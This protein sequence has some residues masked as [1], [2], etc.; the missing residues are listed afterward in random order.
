M[1][2]IKNYLYNVVYQVLL[3]IV[4]LIT[5]PY[6][7]RVLGP[8]LVGINSYTNSWMTFFMLIGQMGISLYGNREIA[9]HRENKEQ[10]S[11]IFWGIEA[12]QLLTILFALALYITAVMLFSTTFKRYFLL[13]TF[14]IIAA[15]VDVSWY[16]MGMENF[17]RTVTR[18]LVVKIISVIMILALIKNHNDLGK[19]IVILGGS[20]LV[21]NLT[22]WPYLKKEIV[23]VPLIEWKPFSHFYPSLLLFIPTITTQ[24]YLVVNRLMLGRMS[25]QNQLGQFE[26]TDKIIKIILAVVTASGQVM[27]P[28][29]ANKFSNGNVKGVRDSLYNSFDF[30]T[31]LAV[32]MMFGVMAVAEPLAPWFLGQAF[33]PA[34]E[35]MMV[36][37]PIIL[38]IAWS[39]VTGIQYLMPVNRTNEYTISVSIGA[40]VNIVANMFLIAL[41]AAKG[42][43]LATDVS[44]FAVTAVQLYYIRNTISRRKLFSS[45]WKYLLCGLV[46]FLI[47]FRLSHMIKMSV[48]NLVVEV[49]TGALAYVV[50]I[51]LIH[52]P[53]VDQA[54]H[55]ISNRKKDQNRGNK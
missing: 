30:I 14:W 47:V 32:P 21:G 40:V 4:P 54:L 52:A 17:Q 53:I 3:L 55:L 37:A 49:I 1:K 5:V 27:L 6:I 51:I 15:G 33:A 11:K 2:V 9:Y 25:T 45:V 29:I 20:N 34:G 28:H 26:N 18:N 16:F 31:A 35:L 22:L 50:G 42:A 43:A 39:N 8:D 12:L 36:E 13:Q 48:P 46:M 24:I 44:E 38:F 41:F 10:R 19:Y 23:W 7:S